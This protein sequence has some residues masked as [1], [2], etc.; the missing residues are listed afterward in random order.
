MPV[1]LM[2][3]SAPQEADVSLILDAL[4]R[5]SDGGPTDPASGSGSDRATRAD[6][7]LAT[8]GYS[9]VRQPSGTP[10]RKLIVY[11]AAAMALGFVGLSGLILLLAPSSPPKP[12]RTAA[13]RPAAAPPPAL[14][15]QPAS[16]APQVGPASHPLALPP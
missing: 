14:R 9:P 8:L 2:P 10:V 6:T 15:P 1:G 4:R 7:V 12:V 5:K 11:G 13:A 16:P 3:T